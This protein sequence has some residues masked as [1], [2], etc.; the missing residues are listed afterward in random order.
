MPEK[1][2][3]YQKGDDMRF[4]KIMLS[5]VMM[6]IS[7]GAFACPPGTVSNGSGGCG[8][9]GPTFPN[10]PTKMQFSGTKCP[11]GS[12]R[13]SSGK[14][15]VGVE[16]AIGSN[17]KKKALNNSVKRRSKNKGLSK[18]DAGNALNALDI[19]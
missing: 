1:L 18:S 4:L 15:V 16:G 2:R 19:R 5:F 9:T 11:P 6:S 7:N 10:P 17:E 14:C 12:I 13:I 8:A 3:R